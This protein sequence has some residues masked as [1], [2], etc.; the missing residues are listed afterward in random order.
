[1]LQPTRYEWAFWINSQLL[2]REELWQQD[3]CSYWPGKTSPWSMWMSLPLE[4]L[5]A[6]MWVAIIILV[7]KYDAAAGKL[8]L[9]QIRTGIYQVRDLLIYLHKRYGKPD[10]TVEN[11]K[12]SDF[13]NMKG[14]M[15]FT[16][17]GWSDASG[18]ATLWNGKTCSDHYYFP[19]PSEA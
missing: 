5:L 2:Q 16:V 10:K 1:M 9:G 6:A 17:N 11:P 8:C 14:I 15:V 18:H 4:K 13:E 7:L 12:V 19:M 3:R